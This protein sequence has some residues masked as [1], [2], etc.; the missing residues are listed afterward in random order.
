[1]VGKILQVQE[2]PT[3]KTLKKADDDVPISCKEV[4]S[5]SLV[6]DNISYLYTICMSPILL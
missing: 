3:F 5:S 1:M 4:N 2:L 6:Y